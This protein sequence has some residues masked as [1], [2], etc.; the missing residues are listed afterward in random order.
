M[1]GMFC[2][3]QD[4][5]GGQFNVASGHRHGQRRERRRSGPSLARN[6]PGTA[7]PM[8]EWI[9]LTWVSL[10][11]SIHYNN[12]FIVKKTLPVL[13]FEPGPFW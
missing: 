5:A 2:R 11:H 10:P 7:L 6:R 13:G 9:H 12:D 3:I 1:I 8:G 4:S